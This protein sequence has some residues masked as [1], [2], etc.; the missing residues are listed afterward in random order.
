MRGALL[1]FTSIVFVCL[2]SSGWIVS[3]FAI[4]DISVVTL[5]TLR[6]LVVLTVLWVFLSSTGS[7]RKIKRLNIRGHMLVGVL[8]HATYL[9]AAVGAFE[10]GASAA[11]VAFI[12][13]LQPMV[14]AI[15]S[16]HITSEAIT[17]RQWQGMLIGLCAVLLLVSDGY[18][19]GVNAYA[20]VLPFIAVFGLSIGTLINRRMELDNLYW[21]RKPDPVLPVLFLQ[22][23][24]ALS[25]LIPMSLVH[26][27]IDLDLNTEQWLV[28]LWL[29]LVVSLGAYAVLLLLIRNMSAMRVSSLSYLVPPATMIQAWLV[30]GE[31]ISMLDVAALLIAAIG[32]YLVIRP[33]GKEEAIAPSVRRRHHRFG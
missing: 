11:L 8:S 17:L 26:G 18:R 4:E 24:G 9:I 3:R 15:M 16:R 21:K 29:A 23:A 27:P 14:T 5:L 10:A 33:S 19:H 12:T 7:W 13:A 6:Y 31:S 28:V 22:C 30:L 32:V 25:I 20:L 1:T 2:W